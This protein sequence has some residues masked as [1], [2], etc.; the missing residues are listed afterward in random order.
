VQ[1]HDTVGLACRYRPHSPDIRRVVLGDGDGVDLVEVA[2]MIDKRQYD[3]IC[4]RL[5]GMASEAE[6]KR[7][8]A[9]LQCQVEHEYRYQG[10]RAGLLKALDLL[11]GRAC[12]IPK[13]GGD[14]GGE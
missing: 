12:E 10:E 7:Q 3:A 2:R 9:A 4:A 5:Q 11:Q 1:K 14:N 8:Y 13:E 6:M